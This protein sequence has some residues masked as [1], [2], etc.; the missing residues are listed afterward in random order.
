MKEMI[1]GS[2]MKLSFLLALLAILTMRLGYDEWK[3]FHQRQLLRWYSMESV[4]LMNG[5]A[6]AGCA[7]VGLYDEKGNLKAEAGCIQAP[8]TLQKGGMYA[9]VERKRP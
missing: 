9:F 4:I 6:M 2:T 3:M 1:G 5:Q 8:F 7:T